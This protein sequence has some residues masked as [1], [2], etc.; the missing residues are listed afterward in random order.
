MVQIVV[1]NIQAFGLTAE[2]SSPPGGQQSIPYTLKASDA[3]VAFDVLFDFTLNQQGL[4]FGAPRSVFVDNSR[5]PNAILVDVEGPGQQFPVPPYSAGVFTISSATAARKVSMSSD[6]GADGIVFFE[7]YNFNKAPYVW[8]GFA[9]FIPGVQVLTKPDIGIPVARNYTLLAATAHDIFPAVV[10]PNQKRFRNL[11]DTLCY[12]NLN[13]AAT[14]SFAAGDCV[15]NP[16]E[17]IEL[18][19]S[20]SGAISFYSADGGNIEAYEF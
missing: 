20:Y 4:L 17:T 1:S 19:F 13:V 5:N 11:S 12:Y 10:T 18:K 2:Q 7:F 9:P 15:I 3:A 6:G 8:S 16:G 14:G